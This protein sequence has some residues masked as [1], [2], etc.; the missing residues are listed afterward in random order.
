MSTQWI[1]WNLRDAVS[2]HLNNLNTKWMN[3]FKIWQ[4]Q[5]ANISPHPASSWK[6]R[7]SNQVIWLWLKACHMVTA[8]AFECIGLSFLSMGFQ[9]VDSATTWTPCWKYFPPMFD[10]LLHP[11]P[12]LHVKHVMNGLYDL[13]CLFPFFYSVLHPLSISNT[14]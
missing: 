14:F 1:Y 6:C 13:P 9:C 12:S 8:L 11:C 3:L 10:V 7:S 2:L 5:L 4:I